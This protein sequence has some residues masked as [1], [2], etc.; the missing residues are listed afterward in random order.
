MSETT[1]EWLPDPDWH[2][3]DG[4]RA[5]SWHGCNELAVAYFWRVRGTRRTRRQFCCSNTEHLYGRRIVNG[6]VENQYLIGSCAHARAL[7]ASSQSSIAT[8]RTGG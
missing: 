7:K 5:C 1:H 4:S 3:V 8:E 6:V 2:R